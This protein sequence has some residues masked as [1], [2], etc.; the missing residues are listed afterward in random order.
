MTT[1]YFDS[2][3]GSDVKDGKSEANAKASYNEFAKTF[4]G[5]LPGDTYLFKR[6]ATQ[7]AEIANIGVRT[8]ASNTQRT[9]YGAYGVAQVPYSIWTPPPSGTPNNAYILNVSAR[10]YIDFED[11]YFDGLNRVTYTLYM[12][13][14]G[15]SANIGHKLT[16]CLFTNTAPSAMGI[17][18]G[19]GMI[20]GGTATS[21]G[22]TSDYLFE[23]CE[24]FNNPV[25]G[26][27]V[28][29]AHG[30]V[31]RRCK[32]YGNGFNAPFGG[33]GF[34]SKYRLQETTPSGWIQNGLVWRRLLTT[35]YQVDVYYVKTNVGGYG[36][37]NKKT[38]GDL[39]APAA[40]EFSVT[41]GYL[42]I[43]VNSVNNPASQAVAYAWGRCYDLLIE[44]CEAYNNYNDPASPYTEGHGFAFDNWA[45]DS[46]FRRNISY[47]NQGSGF[48]INMGDNNIIEANIAYGNKSS[49]VSMAS[50]WNSK[51]IQNTFFDNN[52]GPTGIRTNGEIT[53]FPNCKAGDI[54]NNILRKIGD[55]NYGIEIYS[56]VTG[57]TGK[58]NCI[59][60]YAN[61]ESGSNFL[62][63]ILVN[64]NLD[65]RHRPNASELKGAGLYIVRKDFYGREFYSAPNI[66][67]VENLPT[68]AWNSVTRQ[69]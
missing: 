34:S 28:N 13:A 60:G 20:I 4:T 29:G 46:I 14:S 37:L 67:A 63:T 24:F 27:I 49:A 25:H 39:T 68:P 47:N 36:R 7:I 18:N 2:V 62:E 26:M 59:H 12:L 66:G 65:A 56:G 61:V 64:P 45:D 21:T 55:A 41:G 5:A 54:S 53:A 31:V 15:A 16:R 22:D 1:W 8:G 30:V 35:P 23:D 6:G 19:S 57:F 40:G 48:S 43:N 58:R 51:I 69:A 44:E 42:Y 32:F 33:H 52:Q 50:S 11:M 9:R 38:T 3:N 10:N 17:P